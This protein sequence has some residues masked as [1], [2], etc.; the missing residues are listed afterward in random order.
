V[1]DFQI[2][3]DLD[4]AG[5]LQGFRQIE[6]QAQASGQKAGLG[7]QDGLNRFGKR[8]IAALSEELARLQS[9]QVRLNV[10]SSAF[11]KTGAKIR[12]LE[13]LIQQ[14]NRRQLAVNTDP[15]SLVVM[16]QR[17][18]DLNSELE[19]VKVGSPAFKALKRDVAGAAAE[20]DK[21]EKAAGRAQR[22]FGGLIQTLAGLGAGA[23]VL[24]FFRS[25]I[26]EAIELE[27][28]TRKLSNTLGAQGAAGAL[29]FTRKLSADLGLSFKTLAG[30]FASFTAAASAA[31]VPMEVQKD[32]FAAVAKTGQALGLSND[33]L[34]G[35]LLA[36][37]QVASK[38]TVQMEELRGQ[39]GERMPIAFAATAKGLGITSAELIKLVESGKL[40]ASQFFPALTKG[41]NELTAGSGGV[42]TAAQN[43]QKLANAWTDLQASFGT[44]LLPIVT[45]QVTTLTQALEGLGVEL[46]AKELRQSFGLSVDEAEQLVGILGEIQTRYNLSAQ[47]AKNLLSVAI[48]NTGAS[49][50]WFGELNLG[51]KRFEK[52]QLN[53]NDLAKQFRATNRDL[54]A[55]KQKEGQAAVTLA[56]QE[57][58]RVKLKRESLALSLAEVD[59]VTAVAAAQARAASAAAGLAISQRDAV[60]S[61]GSAVQGVEQSRFDIAR[62]FNQ[63]ELSQLQERGASE[64]QL[65]AKRKEGEAIELQ[66][67]QAKIQSTR[68]MQ[69][70]ELQTLSIKQQQARLEAATSLDQAVL[71]AKKAALAVDQASLETDVKKRDVAVQ[72]AQANLEIANLDL[73]A[74]LGKKA[75][76]EQLQPLEAATVL[77]TQATARN[78]QAA[79]AAAKDYG[80]A[81]DGTLVKIK[82]I[83]GEFQGLSTAT[84]LAADQQRRLA[85][86]AQATG[87][88]TRIAADGSVEIGQAIKGSTGGA[89]ALA[90]SFTKV[91]D[92]APTAA[93]GARDFAG[94]LSKG[95]NFAKGIAGVGIDTVVGSAAQKAGGL[96][97]QMNSAANAADR[98]YGSLLNA[99]GLPGAYFTGGPVGAGERIRINDGPGGRSLGQE[100][101]LSS[102]GSLSLIN[103]PANSLWVTPSSGMVVPAAVTDQLKSA[104]AFGPTK[105]LS[106]V[107]PRAAGGDPATAAL[108]VEVSRLRAEVSELN[109]KRWDV[110][111]QLRQD[112]SGLRMQRM[113]NNMS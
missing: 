62:S 34:S 1:S 79:E 31:N 80:V 63:Y 69:G 83:A 42:E 64:A 85:D 41:L 37:Q 10:D 16:R 81:V 26:N 61:Y 28:I 58:N 22:G 50:D 56:D 88:Q 13:G 2:S 67:L 27:T 94:F 46:K 5:I 106:R 93:Q 98:F 92:A 17:V 97:Q 73:R 60:L 74:A 90:G 54:V 57:A 99:S 113:L 103:R 78:Q 68:V 86:L 24:G 110:N 30:T 20:L 49:R 29:S 21:A 111:V 18:A 15:R 25:S 48:A 3:V 32:L 11:A 108:A 39:L 55:E 45:K 23:A 75:A 40:T 96:A 36:L 7:I 14:V 72:Q 9:R 107:T 70:V 104:G 89:N 33:E 102:S 35:S 82:G 19:R 100:S 43:F 6:S 91:G 12:E 71:A 95:Q 53:L 112:G 77:A 51:G 109:R 65:R 101:F 38:G 47:Q 52:V 44:S 87:L 105:T 4:T 66:A 8:S 59:A 76:L 84:G